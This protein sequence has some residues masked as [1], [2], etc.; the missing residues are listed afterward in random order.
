MDFLLLEPFLLSTVIFHWELALALALT[1]SRLEQTDRAIPNGYIGDQG[2]SSYLKAAAKT[3]TIATV[4]INRNK[5][6]VNA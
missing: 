3:V 1:T 2:S 5:K 6:T 4:L